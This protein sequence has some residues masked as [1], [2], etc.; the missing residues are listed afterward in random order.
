[1]MST[2]TAL[3]TMAVLFAPLHEEYL[4]VLGICTLMSAVSMTS[5][6]VAVTGRVS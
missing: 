3:A 4:L 6:R 2:L 1:M 5:I